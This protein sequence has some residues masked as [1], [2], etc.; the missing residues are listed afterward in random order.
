M[1]A[2]IWAAGVLLCV[3]LAAEL[4]IEDRAVD[5]DPLYMKLKVFHIFMLPHA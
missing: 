1:K 5:S 4:P 3:F 2:D